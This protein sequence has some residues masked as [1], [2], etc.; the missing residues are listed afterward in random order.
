MTVMAVSWQPLSPDDCSTLSDKIVDMKQKF[1]DGVPFDD[2]IRANMKQSYALQRQ[3]INGGA[4]FNDVKNEFPYLFSCIPLLDNFKEFIGMNANNVLSEAMRSKGLRVYKCFKE[5]V[6]EFAG[7]SDEY[8][9]HLPWLVA[10]YFKED[11]T[12]LLK[13]VEVRCCN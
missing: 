1:L 5:E 4:K 3:L 6:R 2:D 8:V 7:E 10:S 13:V 9:R 11:K 12:A